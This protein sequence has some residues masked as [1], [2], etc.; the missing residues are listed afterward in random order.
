MRRHTP[1]LLEET[2]VAIVTACG[3]NYVDA[4][5]GRGGHGRALLARLGAKAR[6]LALDRDAQAIA[7]AAWLGRTEP[8]MEVEQA[9]FSQLA[10][11]VRRRGMAPLAGVLMDVGVS[12]PQLEDAERGFSFLRDGPLDMRMD[13]G[14]GVTAAQW[15]NAA[16]AAELARAFRRLGGER[17][18]ER[19]ARAVVA[20]RPLARTGDLTAA[21][22]AA[23][24]QDRDAARHVATRVFQ[25]VRITVNDELGE[26]DAGL[27]AAFTALGIGGRLAVITFHSLEHRLVRRRFRAWREGGALLRRTPIRG[28]PK[29]QAR[30]VVGGARPGAAEVG[31]NPRARSAM[32]QVV[33]KCA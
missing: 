13:R 31:R 14:A 20:R 19:I 7:D 27:D 1:V 25:A 24:K 28:E 23:S 3:G 17:D 10:A 26:L 5:W 4:T 33:E 6:L 8:R 11:V 29:R 32:L 22:T 15:L 30:L 2:L 12:S 16:D 9:R 21:I 18:A